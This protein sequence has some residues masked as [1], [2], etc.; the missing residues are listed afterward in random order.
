MVKARMSEYDSSLRMGLIAINLN[1]GD[2]LV[3]VIQTSGNDDVFMVS[4]QGMTIRFSKMTCGRWVVR[5]QV[6]VE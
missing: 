5:P 6:C 2:E 3:R 4:Q 1:G